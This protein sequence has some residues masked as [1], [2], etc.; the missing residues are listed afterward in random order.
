MIMSAWHVLV[1]LMLGLTWTVF[2]AFWIW[3]V[4]CANEAAKRHQIILLSPCYDNLVDDPAE[5]FAGIELPVGRYKL[6][7]NRIVMGLLCPQ[8]QSANRRFGM[9]FR[10]STHQDKSGR[11]RGE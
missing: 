6:T 7:H 10:G 11:R 2:V 4:N 9:R 3:L 5:Q 8:R 1:A